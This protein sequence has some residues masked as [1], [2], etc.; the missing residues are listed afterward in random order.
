MSTIPARLPSKPAAA[1]VSIASNATLIAL[2]LV[3]GAL[4]GSVAIIT[5]AIHS[6][7]DLLASVV[8]FF[9]VREADKPAD[10]EHPYGHE[11][12]EN[13]A[14]AIEGMLI[15]VGAG[16]VIYESAR[17]LF[18]GSELEN[19]GF[20]IA[21]IALS[22]LVNLAVSTYLYRRARQCSSPALEGDAAHL[23]TD[24]ATSA[25]VLVGLTVMELTGAQWL[26]PLIALAVAGAIVV[27]GVRL[28]TRSGR[29]LVDEALPA[30]D[31]EAVRQEIHGFGPRGVAGFHALRGR[32]AGA[33][34]L[35]DLHVQ[36][37]AGTTL[38]AAHEV[39]HDLQDAIRVRLHDADVLIHLEPADSVRPGSEVR[40]AGTHSPGPRAS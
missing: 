9:S 29:V 30:D 18:T 6:G 10:R 11:K 7:I 24:A 2:K 36:F 22:V 39:A 3:A 12:V 5:E 14:A 25:G 19:L 8:A 37:R 40:P 15:L 31:L 13:L 33:R 34:A 17:R 28:L 20:G 38:E 1:A 21:I 16:I 26:D 27:A 35:V 32:R 4:T 23:R